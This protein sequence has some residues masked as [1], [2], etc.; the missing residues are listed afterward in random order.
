MAAQLAAGAHFRDAGDP[1]DLDDLEVLELPVPLVE[2]G[3]A[4][5]HAVLVDGFGNVSLD[6]THEHLMALGLTLGARADVNGRE[7]TV[8]QTFADVAAGALLLYEDAWGAIAVAVNRGDAAAAL[9]VERDGEVR[10]APR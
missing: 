8:V 3:A 1:L 4:T 5:G 10:V 7:A 2:P 6:L 9:G